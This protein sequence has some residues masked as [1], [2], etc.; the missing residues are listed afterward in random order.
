MNNVREGKP[1][2]NFERRADT[3]TAHA[4][5]NVNLMCILAKPQSG[6]PSPAEAPHLQKH[7]YSLKRR[8]PKA[9]LIAFQK[10]CAAMAAGSPPPRAR[11]R[12]REGGF[13]R[14]APM[15]LTLSTALC[16]SRSA[17]DRWRSARR[18]LPVAGYDSQ[19]QRF[20]TAP[21][22]RHHEEVRD[23][24]IMKKYV[25]LLDFPI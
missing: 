22:L 13:G 20:T 19:I 11:W 9:R 4:H 23:C 21:S 16:T 17:V 10:L 15:A 1:Q 8:C 2:Y 3:C 12:W 5:V 7:S 25:V 18:F 14:G 6:S 24:A